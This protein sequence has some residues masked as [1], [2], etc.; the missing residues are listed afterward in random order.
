MTYNTLHTTCLA[1]LLVQAKKQGLHLLLLPFLSFYLSSQAYWKASLVTKQEVRISCI[2][3]G[4]SP[5]VQ[6]HVVIYACSVVFPAKQ[7]KHKKPVHVARGALN[8]RRWCMCSFVVSSH[9]KSRLRS[10]SRWIVLACSTGH[11]SLL[12]R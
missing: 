8:F 6:P 9:A 3:A 10:C 1:F 11:S 5:N 7:F 12:K 4:N 2:Q